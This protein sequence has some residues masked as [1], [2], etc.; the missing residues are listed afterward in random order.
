[1]LASSPPL[2][3]L[4][5]HSLA[6]ASENSDPFMP[7]YSKHCYYI[8]SSSLAFNYNPNGCLTFVK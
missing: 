1:M 5:F 3:P 2:D 7:S 6:H 8:Y 4:V